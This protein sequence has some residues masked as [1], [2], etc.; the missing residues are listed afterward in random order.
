MRGQNYCPVPDK[1]CYY[2]NKFYKLDDSGNLITGKIPSPYMNKKI[3]LFKTFYF[4][5]KRFNLDYFD[6]A[7]YKRATKQDF[8]VGTGINMVFQPVNGYP[9]VFSFGFVF[10]P[11]YIFARKENEYLYLGMPLTLGF[12]GTGDSKTIDLSLGIMLD[13]PLIFNYD[14]EFGS[15]KRGGS[16]FGYFAGGGIAYHYNKYSVSSDPA[17]AV[18]QVN[19]FGPV[20]NAG[21]RYS[22]SKYRIHSYELKFSY[23]K[24][25]VESKPDIFGLGFIVNF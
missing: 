16:R 17:I 8:G 1:L 5:E 22:L 12:S 4:R 14:Y 18:Q 13:L 21:I 9:A 20:V 24:M 7:Y 19:G 3:P 25:I 10:S 23:M 2:K 6:S 11:R 15:L